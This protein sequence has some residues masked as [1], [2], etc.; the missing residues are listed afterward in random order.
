MGG[1]GLGRKSGIAFR[2]R[3]ALL[4]VL[5]ESPVISEAARSL[6]VSPETGSSER[7]DTRADLLSTLSPAPGT[8]R[9]LAVVLV[10]QLGE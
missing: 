10:S 1:T 9:A 5:C 4:N 2:Q 3:E 8:Q 6:C 7:A